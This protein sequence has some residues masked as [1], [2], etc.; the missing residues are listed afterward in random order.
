MKTQFDKQL[1]ELQKEFLEKVE[2]AHNLVEL[3]Q[4]QQEFNNRYKHILNQAHLLGENI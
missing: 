4:L 2:H 1:T 3:N